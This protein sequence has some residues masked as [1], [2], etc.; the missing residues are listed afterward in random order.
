MQEPVGIWLAHIPAC[1]VD[2]VYFTGNMAPF[3]AL[4]ALNLIQSILHNHTFSTLPDASTH[5][6]V[7]S[8]AWFP[9]LNIP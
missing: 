1:G 2:Q 6:C 3:R 5:V 8:F 9:T 4:I 7:P